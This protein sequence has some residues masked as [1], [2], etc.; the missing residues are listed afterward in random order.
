[1]VSR[2]TRSQRNAAAALSSVAVFAVAA[3][4]A[5]R[6]TGQLDAGAPLTEVAIDAST[7]EPQVRAEVATAL[8]DVLD[9]PDV[10]ETARQGTRRAATLAPGVGGSGESSAKEDTEEAESKKAAGADDVL[11]L[12]LIHI[13]EPTRP[14]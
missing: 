11:L 6:W 13:S 5:W 8:V 7:P 9:L 4:V 3:L 2:L 10:K 1:M 12:S 14:Y